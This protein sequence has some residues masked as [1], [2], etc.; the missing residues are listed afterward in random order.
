MT[1]MAFLMNSCHVGMAAPPLGLPTPCSTPSPASKH[2]LSSGEKVEPKGLKA[3]S[4]QSGMDCRRQLSFGEGMETTGEAFKDFRKGASWDSNMCQTPPTTKHPAVLSLSK[5]VSGELDT[6]PCTPSM[7]KEI[8]RVS[9]MLEKQLQ[10]EKAKG[11][12]MEADNETV[13]PAVQEEASCASDKKPEPVTEKTVKERATCRTKGQGQIIPN[14]PSKMPL[15][16]QQHVETKPPF[17]HL[18]L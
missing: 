7:E 1:L 14:R 10:V 13:P 8:D 11:N 9:K 4:K 15:H 5:S 6:T 18:T 3:G 16:D 12:N 17:F 2:S